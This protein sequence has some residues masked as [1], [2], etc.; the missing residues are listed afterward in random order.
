MTVTWVPYSVI[1]TSTAL[2]AINTA[3]VTATSA[4]AFG[5]TVAQTAT[6]NATLYADI[7]RYDGTT[8]YYQVRQEPVYPGGSPVIVQA[9]ALSSGYSV[10]AAVTATTA[11]VSMSVAEIS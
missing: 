5:I 1:P 4:L 9:L 8:H 2:T 10:Y 11:H 6:T 3:A 7:T